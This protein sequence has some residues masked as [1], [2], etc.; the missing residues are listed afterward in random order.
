ML[1]HIK[2]L[3]QWRCVLQ[4]E[5]VRE[6]LGRQALKHNGRAARAEAVT[7]AQVPPPHVVGTHGEAYSPIRF[8][9][10]HFNINK[11]RF[12]TL[13]PPVDEK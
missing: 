13:S 10:V 2:T 4:E 5:V 11:E 7:D 6:A 1:L 9:K 8:T 3:T 12:E